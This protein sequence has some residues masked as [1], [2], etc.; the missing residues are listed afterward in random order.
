[1]QG[2]KQRPDTGRGEGLKA[3]SV[4]LCNSFH[5]GIT[6]PEP[7]SHGALSN[8]AGGLFILFI[9]FI[10]YNKALYFYGVLYLL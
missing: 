3:I 6:I 1:M 4:L 2:E 9:L 8:G 7:F 10:Y 5:V